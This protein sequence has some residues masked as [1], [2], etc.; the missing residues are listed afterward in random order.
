MSL[1][2]PVPNLSL[3]NCSLTS[4]AFRIR[5]QF[6]IHYFVAIP[7]SLDESRILQH[8]H[9]GSTLATYVR[10]IYLGGGSFD[11]D[12]FFQSRWRPILD[13]FP[14]LKVVDLNDLNHKL[15]LSPETFSPQYT[16]V[17]S[18]V[19]W[20]IH[21]PTCHTILSLLATLPNLSNLS[22]RSQWHC[23]GSFAATLPRIQELEIWCTEGLTGLECLNTHLDFSDVKNLRLYWHADREL[24]QIKMDS[25]PVLHLLQEASSSLKNVYFGVR[26]FPP[27]RK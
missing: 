23:S 24:R 26:F 15:P 21:I 25:E 10:K 20:Q 7:N 4:R 6:H 27:F 11:G 16:T 17:T 22:L 13:L 18:L 9:R 19:L 3:W 1:R 2:N 12:T 14:K 8:Y 5:S